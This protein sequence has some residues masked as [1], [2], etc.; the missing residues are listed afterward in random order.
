MSLYKINKKI[1]LFIYLNTI[2]QICYFCYLIF[3]SL[4]I[5]SFHQFSTSSDAL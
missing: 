1:I 3:L 2:F 4:E 5:L